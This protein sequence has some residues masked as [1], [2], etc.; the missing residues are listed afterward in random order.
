MTEITV[1]VIARIGS[2]ECQ[3]GTLTIRDGEPRI[4]VDAERLRLAADVFIDLADG[5]A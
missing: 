4:D 1:P 5:G 2:T 3:V